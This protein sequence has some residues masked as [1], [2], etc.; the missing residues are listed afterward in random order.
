MMQAATNLI[1]QPEDKCTEWTTVVTVVKGIYQY[2]QEAKVEK[3]TRARYN[4]MY[5]NKKLYLACILCMLH[6]DGI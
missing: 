4:I 1:N 3:E 2:V 6:S 5:K